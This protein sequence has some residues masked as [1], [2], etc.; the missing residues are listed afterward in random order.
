MHEGRGGVARGTARYSLPLRHLV[1][2]WA[3]AKAGCCKAAWVSLH[4]SSVTYGMT[5]TNQKANTQTPSKNHTNI[6]QTLK[7]QKKYA[8]LCSFPLFLCAPVFSGFL[9]FLCFFCSFALSL[10][11]AS[12]FFSALLS[13]LSAPSSALFLSLALFLS[14]TLFLSL[15]LFSALFLSSALLLSSTL[16]FLLL[17]PS[18]CLL[19][20]FPSFPLFSSSHHPNTKYHA[21]PSK[22]HPSFTPSVPVCLCNKHPTTSTT[23][24]N[25]IK[26]P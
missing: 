8:L 9:L 11:S 26:Q 10:S 13:S 3:P 14:S 19:Y 21:K 22:Y 1:S 4:D 5:M 20:C 15:A 2:G 17:V 12:F 16:S 24:P 6:I 7:N 23:K 25:E 18:L